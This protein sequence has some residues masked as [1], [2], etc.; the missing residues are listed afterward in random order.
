MNS[1]ALIAGATGLIGSNLA[2]HLLSKGWEV[3]GLARKPQGGNPAVRPVAAD[4]L[5]PEALRTALAGEPGR[6]P[7]GSRP[8]CAQVDKVLSFYSRNNEVEVL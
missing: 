8:S 1:R 3:C 7:R 6:S 4:M 5:N 2:E